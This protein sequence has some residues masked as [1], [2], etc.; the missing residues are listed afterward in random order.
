MPE[1]PVWWSFSEY[2][3]A[4]RRADVSNGVDVDERLEKAPA[5]GMTME[6]RDKMIKQCDDAIAAAEKNQ[7]L[8]DS[9]AEMK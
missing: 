2:L 4:V 3:L 7:R 5:V 6:T 8:L 1:K 9:R